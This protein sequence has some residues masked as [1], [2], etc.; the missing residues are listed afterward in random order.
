MDAACGRAGSDPAT[1]SRF[2]EEARSVDPDEAGACSDTVPLAPTPAGSRVPVERSGPPDPSRMWIWCVVAD[3]GADVGLRS[4]EGHARFGPRGPD[5]CR[6]E[7]E[8]G[9]VSWWRLKPGRHAL[10]LDDIPNRRPWLPY[11][12]EGV[13][14]VRGHAVGLNLRERDVG[15]ARFA[16]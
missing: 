13:L 12:F 8:P 7:V 9:Q 1:F 5:G 6:W 2:M 11:R 3:K 15:S 14:V 4:L 10:C 16:P